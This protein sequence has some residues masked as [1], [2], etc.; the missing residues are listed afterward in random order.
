[1]KPSGSKMGLFL[2]CQYPFN[3]QEWPAQTAGR[4]A[5]MGQAYH[6]VVAKL[7]NGSEFLGRQTM[8]RVLVENGLLPEDLPE[9]EAMYPASAVGLFINARAEKAFA[10]DYR[11]GNVRELGEDIGRDYQLNPCELAGTADIVGIRNGAL[12]IADWKTGREAPPAKNNAQLMFL[13]MCANKL[14]DFDEIELCIGH[15][16]DGKIWPDY[17]TVTRF[18]LDIFEAELKAVLSNPSPQPK[19][20]THCRYCPV[21]ATCPKALETLAEKEDEYPLALRGIDSIQSPQHAEWL[22]HRID[23]AEE[24]L[25][26]VK[27][28]VREYADANGAFELSNGKKWGPYVVIRETIQGSREKLIE[29]GIP[30][31]LIEYSVSKGDVEKYAKEGAEKGQGA[32]AVRAMFEKLRDA[33]CVKESMFTKYEARK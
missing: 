3:G 23:A 11:T 28:K 1:M 5:K 6:A 15:I 2:A 19:P 12:L 10:W 8:S 18:D 9:L 13:A 14:A 7:V 24:L 29:A 31:S 16:V 4:P 20:G 33:G 30:E 22:L 21:L 25:S 26:S 17:D 32:A 27:A